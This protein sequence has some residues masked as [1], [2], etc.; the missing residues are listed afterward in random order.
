MWVVRALEFQMDQGAFFVGRFTEQI[1][2]GLPHLRQFYIEPASDSDTG[3][4]LQDRVGGAPMSLSFR[5]MSGV[6]FPEG[7]GGVVSPNR[8]G[9]GPE[10][11]ALRNFVTGGE[12]QDTLEFGIVLPARSSRYQTWPSSVDHV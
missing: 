4:L 9:I 5:H 1:D 10:T 2:T 7:K 12:L 11:T 8:S 3:N 6:S